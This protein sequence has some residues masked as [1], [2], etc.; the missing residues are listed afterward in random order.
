MAKKTPLIST[1]TDP[2]T[3]Y[4]RSVL[5]GE[6]IA[7]PHVRAACERHMRDLVEGHKRGLTFDVDAL[8]GERGV[9]GFFRDVLRLSEGQF[10][11]KPFELH[12]SQQFIVGSIFGWKRADGTRRFRRAYIEQGKGNGKSPLAGGIGLYG[13]SADATPDGG[14][15]EPGAE[16]YAAAATKGQADILF[17]DAVKM[18]R[19]STA[20]ARKITFAGNAKV[21]N[22]AILS[23]PQKGSFF[24][25]VSRDT[26]KSGSGPRPHFALCDEVHEQPDRGTMEMLERGFKF[27]RQPLLFMITNSGTDRKSICWEEHEHAVKVAHGDVEDDTTF[28]YV[29]ALDEGD[30]PLIDPRCWKKANPLLGVVLTEEYLAGV[31]AQA[32]AIPGKQNGILRLHFC[33]WTDAERAWLP[34][35]TWEACED[36]SLKL[37]DF[38]GRRCYAGLDLSATKDLTGKALVF[39]DGFTEDGKPKFAAFGHGYTP[40]DTLR[41]RADVDKAPYDVWAKQGHLIAT[42]GSVIRYDFV[43]SDLVDDQQTYELVQVAYDRHLIKHFETAVGE[44]GAELPLIEHGQGLGQ[45]Q[46]C[47]SDCVE[48]HEHKPAPLWMPGSIESLETLI[49]EKRIRFAVNPALRSAVASARFYTSPAGLRRFDKQ[50]PGGRIDLLIAL[51]MAV[52]AAVGRRETKERAYQMFIVGKAA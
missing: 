21:W 34:R 35:E 14:S 24:R 39:E 20:L 7:G 16:I 43:A 9:F 8:T 26:K 29:C 42:P 44:L 46:G 15:C 48:N 51:V 5:R 47:A 40:K 2:V 45:R 11:G 27:R 32:R 31:V 19:Q 37:A 33:V 25:P 41:A 52:G 13:M 17:Q 22:M 23:A 38:A 49:L 4:A 3:A 6:E 12:P 36:P 10:D 28:S 30:D 18:A 1:S 50:K